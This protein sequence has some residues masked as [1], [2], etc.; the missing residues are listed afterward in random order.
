RNRT[1]RLKE[2]AGVEFVA[3]EYPDIE[4]PTGAGIGISSTSKPDDPAASLHPCIRVRPSGAQVLQARADGTPLLVRQNKVFL[5]LDPIELSGKTAAEEARRRIYSTFLETTA[6]KP[7]PIE[8]NEPWL[9][10]MAQP[11]VKGTVH[12]VYN[13]RTEPGHQ[14][15]TVHTAAGHVRLNTRNRWPAL[16]AVTD[17]GKIV[18]VNAFGEASIGEDPLLRGEGMK[19]LLSLD[20]QDLR[21]SRAV[22]ITP[23]QRGTLIMPSSSTT[24]DA[25]GVHVLDFSGG[26]WKEYENLS[27]DPRNAMVELDSDRA[28]CVL[29]LDRGSD[30]RW[31]EHLKQAMLGPTSID[32]Y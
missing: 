27:I 15:V 3:E 19:A 26:Q 21:Q 22:L 20:G 6:V 9:H 31:R 25:G 12:A 4:R 10:V 32:G 14:E 1:Q 8:P 17:D 13:R 29:V 5:C 7:L 30:G 2:L 23:F 24:N 18:A 16:A 28:T 11:T